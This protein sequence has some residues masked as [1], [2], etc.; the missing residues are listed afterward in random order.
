MLS[1]QA[2]LDVLVFGVEVVQDDVG[3]AGVAGCE[4]DYLEVTGEVLEELEGVGADVD[5][6]LDDLAGGE[7][8]GQFDVVGDAGVLVAVDQGLVQ[9]EYD[10]LFVCIR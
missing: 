8:Y 3:V 6:G 9:V 5:A 2:V 4:D 1:V 7:G 10:C